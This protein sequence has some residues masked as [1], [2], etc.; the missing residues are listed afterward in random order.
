MLCK[1]DTEREWNDCTSR[2]GSCRMKMRG[3]L[4]V[5]C[6][7]EFSNNLLT[8]WYTCKSRL[9]VVSVSAEARRHIWGGPTS[10][11][12]DEH[13]QQTE[14]Q[15]KLTYGSAVIDEA[16]SLDLVWFA[17]R[18]RCCCRVSRCSWIL[19]YRSL[20][21][22]H[23]ILHVPFSLFLTQ[24]SHMEMFIFCYMQ[25]NYICR[26]PSV[27]LYK[28]CTGVYGHWCSDTRQKRSA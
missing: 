27:Y 10:N 9:L 18:F 12:P 14:W 17:G 21:T 23:V 7:Q 20:E 5:K 26:D 25:V 15:Y 2:G 8:F 22:M 28:R 19:C 11:I 6:Y 13:L 1:I 16:Q 3:S 24:M 4:K